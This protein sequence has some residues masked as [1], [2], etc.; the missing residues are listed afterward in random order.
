MSYLLDAHLNSQVHNNY[1]QFNSQVIYYKY[2]VKVI[3]AVGFM[4]GAKVVLTVGLMVGVKVVQPGC[5][6]K[7][8]LLAET[9]LSN[10]PAL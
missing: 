5:M 7:R 6:T 3:A 8:W 1:E 10:L 2:H 4:V 9:L